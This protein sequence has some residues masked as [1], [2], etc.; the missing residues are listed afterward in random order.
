MVVDKITQIPTAI[1]SD[2]ALEKLVISDSQLAIP[3]SIANL[4]NLKELHL[5]NNTITAPLPT[6]ILELK[7]TFFNFEKNTPEYVQLVGLV[8]FDYQRNKIEIEQAKAFMVLLQNEA[9]TLG[10]DHLTLLIKALSYRIPEVRKAALK[11]LNE[12]LQIED[13]P[14][15]SVVCSLGNP[16]FVTDVVSRAKTL[17][18]IIQKKISAKT[19]HIVLAEEAVVTEDLTT[20]KVITTA[21]NF[22]DWLNRVDKLFLAEKTND[23]AIAFQNVT[24]LLHSKDEGNVELALQMMKANGVSKELL[25]E[26][27]IFFNETKFE[28]TKRA[29]KALFKRHAPDELIAFL[30]S[31]HNRWLSTLESYYYDERVYNFLLETKHMDALLI[32]RKRYLNWY[33]KNAKSDEVV[34]LLHELTK[35]G[36]LDL[37][38]YKMTFIPNEVS[39]LENLKTLKL[40]TGINRR[41]FDD[42]TFPLSITQVRQL[43]GLELA[44]YQCNTIPDALKLLQNLRHLAL[45]YFRDGLEVVSELNNLEILEIPEDNFYKMTSLRQ[46]K[47]LKTCIIYSDYPQQ[48]VNVNKKVA[49]KCLP[50]GC[51]VSTR[52]LEES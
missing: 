8:L 4:Q 12:L 52:R 42:N 34:K 35:D 43:E 22:E 48:S 21:D 5:I 17:G 16:S 26:L 3:P 45:P 33:L 7:S 41:R 40:N 29:A 2:T 11:K 39:K 30:K 44:G 15:K 51:K 18:L 9:D 14:K 37:T 13:I 47:N 27:F 19:T 6:Q 20:L 25:G 50:P 28:K 36:V 10:K 32:S 1:L 46:M 38:H 24:D 49:E 23:N 31:I